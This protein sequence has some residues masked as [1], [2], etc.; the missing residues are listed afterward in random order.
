MEG[1]RSLDLHWIVDC[2][3]HSLHLS[4]L[5]CCGYLVRWLSCLDLP[6]LHSLFTGRHIQIYYVSHLEKLV[7]YSNNV[8]L[9]LI[10][11]LSLI[12]LGD[13]SFKFLI[14]YS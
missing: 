4:S 10:N 12:K 3:I 6:M 2:F 1:L 7:S 11:I 13:T 9:L 5:L 8:V 14:N